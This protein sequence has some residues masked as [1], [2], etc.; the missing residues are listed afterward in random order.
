MQLRGSLVVTPGAQH[1]HH[2]EQRGEIREG[3]FSV[4]PVDVVTLEMRELAKPRD[5]RGSEVASL[6]EH[7]RAERPLH[8][9]RRGR[10]LGLDALLER[11]GVV[12]QDHQQDETRHDADDRQGR[13]DYGPTQRLPVGHPVR[14]TI[15]PGLLFPELTPRLVP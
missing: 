8:G 1:H 15:L 9:A 13:N 10:R 3:R 12:R 14:L 11:T 2:V 4:A 7:H 6:V 5:R